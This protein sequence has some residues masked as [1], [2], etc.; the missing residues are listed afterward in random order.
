ME[1]KL[2]E[3]TQESERLEEEN[4]GL[5]EMTKLL[6]VKIDKIEAKIE[7]R[8]TKASSDREQSLNADLDE[9]EY[10]EKELFSRK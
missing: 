3:K 10:L 7:T 2:L 4:I 6:A 8:K 5:N 9:I 1:K